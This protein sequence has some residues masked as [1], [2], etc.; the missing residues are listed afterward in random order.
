ML[1]HFCL[2]SFLLDRGSRVDSEV[3]SVVCAEKFVLTFHVEQLPELNHIYKRLENLS[4]TI[5]LTP[6]W[7]F[8][9]ILDGVVGQHPGFHV[10]SCFSFFLKKTY[11][12]I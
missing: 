3:F 11:S 7:L 5:T 9:S 8:Y 12:L 2:T 1:L 4:S 10:N 6:W